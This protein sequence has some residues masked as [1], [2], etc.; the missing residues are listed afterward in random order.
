MSIFSSFANNEIPNEADIGAQIEKNNK[1]GLF[2]N[3]NQDSLFSN[4]N[5]EY[6]KGSLF[7]YTNSVL[8]SNNKS[9]NFSIFD[10]F[11]KGRQEK[12][13]NQNAYLFS[14]MNTTNIFGTSIN[15]NYN[16]NSSLFN[17]KNNKISEPLNHE[18]ICK[19]TSNKGNYFNI[20]IKNLST[21][22]EINAFCQDEL[23]K[24]EYTKKYGLNELKE[25]K[26]LSICDSIDEIYEELNYEFSTK[27]PTIYENDTNINIY[28]PISHSK[29][30]EIPFILNKIIKKE[31]E[32]KKEELY[33]IIT[34]LQRMK[35]KFEEE[36]KDFIILYYKEIEELKKTVNLY[37]EQMND[38]KKKY[39]EMCEKNKKFEEKISF[40]EKE[41]SSLKSKNK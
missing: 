24:N 20:T 39:E 26:Y 2:S 14:T 40:L 38:N 27:T 6:N 3:Y 32:I 35:Q 11:E 18:Y 17:I 12:N 1:Y 4:D 16:T 31:N 34:D 30:K 8:Y 21:F 33:D 29:Y 7:G 25:I 5:K 22:I 9:N 15:N 36:K 37:Y 19:V 41:I 10:S 28:I 23:K 13:N